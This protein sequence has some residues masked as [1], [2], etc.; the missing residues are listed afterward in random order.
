MARLRNG[1][2]SEHRI[3]TGM[4]SN[5]APGEKVF[6]PLIIAWIAIVV[7]GTIIATLNAR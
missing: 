1:R 6:R 4:T 3:A 5:A 2:D 7:I